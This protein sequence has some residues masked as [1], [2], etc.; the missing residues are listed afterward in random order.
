MERVKQFFL[1]HF[2]FVLVAAVVV[3]VF[4]A[5]LLIE[6]RSAFLSFYYLPVLLSGYYLGKRQAVAT[7]VFSV[8]AV[9]I[10][11]VLTPKAFLSATDSSLY[12]TLDLVSWGAFLLL[13]A[14]VVGILFEAKQAQF[15]QLRV[16]YVGI[17][18]I[19]AKYLEVGDRYTQGH[20]LR[21]ANLAT[22]LAVAMHLSEGDVEN[23]RTAALLHDIGKVEVSGNLIQKAAELT[24]KEKAAVDRHSDKGAEIL[25]S[26]GGVLKDAVPL[27]LYHHRVYEQAENGESEGTPHS[28]IPFGAHIIAV[29]DAY[30]A[31]I[32]DR[33]YRKGRPPWQALQEIERC[34]PKQFNPDVVRAFRQMSGALEKK[35]AQ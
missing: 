4:V 23:I 30:D 21:V 26:V 9:V 34:T 12:L 8:L 6:R 20:S 1:K 13:T 3:S 25:K 14:A 2:E 7:A 29:A 17:V 11:V 33:P 28:E 32:T 16:A 35:D 19:L 5:H 31:I 24:T 22:D 15:E 10:L 18:E 27:V